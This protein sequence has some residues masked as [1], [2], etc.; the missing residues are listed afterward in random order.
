MP[1]KDQNERRAW[2]REYRRNRR[3]SVVGD[4]VREAER[5]R[6]RALSSEPVGERTRYSVS[7]SPLLAFAP[8]LSGIPGD[9]GAF[10]DWRWVPVTRHSAAART[11]G[12]GITGFVHVDNRGDFLS[13]LMDKYP[14]TTE[15]LLRSVAA[16]PGFDGLRWVENMRF[17]HF[18]RPAPPNPP[19]TRWEWLFVVATEA[20]AEER[21]LGR[22]L[23][24]DHP[25]VQRARALVRGGR[26][27]PMGVEAHDVGGVAEIAAEVAPPPA[28]YSE[29][30]ELA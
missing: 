17:G 7:A 24:N 15:R 25:L 2:E 5:E 4:A 22:R 21:R 9:S 30:L 20:E 3:A 1:H 28:R 11:P 8:S 18:P 26:K 29:E 27:P 13:Y 10:G 16:I 23:P 14:A 6:K 12:G 19:R